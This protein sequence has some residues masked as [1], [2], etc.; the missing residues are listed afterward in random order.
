ML[1]LAIVRIVDFCTRHPWWV[2]G[3]VLLLSA[4]ST[5]YAARH[6]AIKTD[7]NELISNQLP[8]TQRA[9]DYMAAFPQREI[10]VVIDA[11]TPELVEQAT[12]RLAGALQDRHDLIR[13]VRQPQS[14]AF[15]ERNGLLFLPTE[16]VQRIA[17]G[18]TRADALLETLAVDPS[19]RGTLD[20]LSFGLT[21]VER[22][23]LKLD[24]MTR[25]MTMAADTVED[26]LAGRPASFSWR[27]LAGG[28]AAQPRDLRRFIEVEP[29]LDFSALQPGHAA[30]NAVVQTAADLHLAE[31]YRAR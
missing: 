19:L 20:A 3:V 16:E 15:F 8:W 5:V 22:K 6:F 11:P 1:K 7:I 23:E 14:G 21:G 4:G 28:K 9:T 10:L 26:V 29:V 31:N 18:L 12:T 25:P 2:L 24:D 17:D 30:T 27:V 13:A